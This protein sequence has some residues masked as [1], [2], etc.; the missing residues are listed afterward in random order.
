MSWMRT[1]KSSRRGK[2][3]LNPFGDVIDIVEYEI[4]SG[5]VDNYNTLACNSRRNFGGLKRDF[6]GSLRT[7][8]Q[9][10]HVSYLPT[11]LC[12]VIV[13]VQAEVDCL[14]AQ[15]AA[16]VLRCHLDLLQYRLPR[17]RS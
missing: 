11:D 9:R 6:A 3:V 12:H 17:N 5:S 15:R 10:V 4:L 2:R 7:G 16:V 14:F 1:S 13:L 8:D